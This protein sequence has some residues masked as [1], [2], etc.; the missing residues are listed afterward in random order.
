MKVFL[1]YGSHSEKEY[2]EK[3]LRSFDGVIF[4]SNLIE[5]TP[6]ATVSLIVRHC[7][8]STNYIIDPMT[9][10][11]GEHVD[12]SGK[13]TKN[14]HWL[15]KDGKIK[16]SYKKLSEKLGSKFS[17]AVLYK[18][19][20]KLSDLQ[21]NDICK[22]IC[23]DTVKYQNERIKNI[24]LED[25][26]Y[27]SFTDGLPNPYLI[28]SP[29]FYIDK[30][31]KNQW[32]D[33]HQKICSNSLKYTDNLYLKLCFDY[34]LLADNEF[35]EGVFNLIQ[36]K[37]KGVCLWAS[38]FDERKVDIKYLMGFKILVK[39]LKEKKVN[40]FNRHGDYFSYIL[41]KYGLTEL[42]YSVGYGSSKD[43]MPVMGKGTPTIN[44]YYPN[45]HG[46]FSIPKIER[47]FKDIGVN[48]ANDFFEKICN[49][50][51]CKG[52]IKHNLKNFGAF[53]KMQYSSEDSKKTSQVPAAAKRA[54]FHY[55]LARLKEKKDVEGKKLAELLEELNKTQYISQLPVFGKEANYIAKWK[56][57]LGD[58]V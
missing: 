12:S 36:D 50:A 47:I 57:V 27:A 40:V 13:L 20:I 15:K 37:L 54:R 33:V 17:D 19:A 23:E 10:S 24:L 26:E 39:K 30:K 38:N 2:F 8:K 46:K 49:C 34:T 18:S 42:S 4:S 1:R 11:F 41:S 31:R 43:V 22:S 53:G 5:A 7:S 14:L 55:L 16:S 3:A 9:Y 28:Y 29:Y 52:V 32:L 56:E 58:D 21:N 48:N 25:K 45:L 44:F 6:A 35:I 51:I